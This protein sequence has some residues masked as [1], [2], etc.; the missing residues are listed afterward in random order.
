MI[1]FQIKTLIPVSETMSGGEIAKDIAMAGTKGAV[2]SVTG[3][4]RFACICHARS[5]CRN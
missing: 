1:C 4:A 2:S 5:A 3:A